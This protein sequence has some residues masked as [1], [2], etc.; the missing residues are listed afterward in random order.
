[1]SSEIDKLIE[2]YKTTST[3]SYSKINKKYKKLVKKYKKLKKKTLTTKI[4]IRG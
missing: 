1:M 2:K 4:K 3:S